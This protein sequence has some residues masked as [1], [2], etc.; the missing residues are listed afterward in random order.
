[1]ADIQGTNPKLPVELEREAFMLAAYNA[2][3]RDIPS[4]IHVARRV[5]FW[6][7]PILYRSFAIC[8]SNFVGESLP[9][10]RTP[11]EFASMVFSSPFVIAQHIRDLWINTSVESIRLR[12][13]IAACSRIETLGISYNL[14]PGILPV[15][16]RMPLQRLS[17]HLELLFGALKIDF[18]H[19]IFSRLTHLSVLDCPVQEVW[20]ESWTGLFELP[21]L[22]HLAFQDFFSGPVVGD[23]LAQSRNLRLLVLKS[24]DDIFRHAEIVPFATHDV[25]CVVIVVK[26]SLKDWEAGVVDRVDYWTKAEEFS[27]KRRTGEVE[28]AAYI[29]V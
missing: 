5:R 25:R 14:L 16:A 4:L 9:L 27:R 7:T 6:V 21:S 19:P 20:E 29:V 28:V 3:I 24:S 10:R 17:I 1:M 26:D 2:Q 23:I 15:L 11:G 18:G 22:T 8:H 12:Q 13:L